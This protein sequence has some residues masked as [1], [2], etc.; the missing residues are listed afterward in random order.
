MIG[1]RADGGRAVYSRLREVIAVRRLLIVFVLPG[2][3]CVV[4]TLAATLIVVSLPAVART[5]YVEHLTALDGV[6]L[7]IGTVL[8]TIQSL[9]SYRA[10][11]WHGSNFH[12]EADNWITKLAQA[13]E[14]FPLLGLIGTVAGIMQT[15][16]Q[17]TG[18]TP[19]ER[20]IQ[21][22][23]PAITATGTGLFM[24]LINILPAWVVLIGRGL[25][26]S[27]AGKGES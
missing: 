1:G 2:L 12:E 26:L 6:I 10:L 16:S 3:F 11:Q 20:I 27:L 24:A 5:F 19:P 14:W 9:L 18:A 23:A 17:I 4:P 13:S 21:M 25:I 15:F 8:F 7:G 22:Y